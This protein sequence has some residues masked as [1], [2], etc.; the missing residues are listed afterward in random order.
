MTTFM[1]FLAVRKVFFSR[2]TWRHRAP[3]SPPGCSWWI[4]C[5][6]FREN[7]PLSFIDRLRFS[8]P[9]RT[10]PPPAPV[11]EFRIFSSS[12]QRS[13]RLHLQTLSGWLKPLA[14]DWLN[15][16]I[17][18]YSSRMNYHLSHQTP[19]AFF[20]VSLDLHL[21]CTGAIS[22][23]RALEEP[24]GSRLASRCYR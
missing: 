19:D 10:S 13:G 14:I 20:M 18:N 17:I 11:S 1:L 2:S 9:S 5:Q 16:N 21:S 4:I 7:K 12:T 22:Y 8:G 15:I 6:N 23:L 24:P 3:V